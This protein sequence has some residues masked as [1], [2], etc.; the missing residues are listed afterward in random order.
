MKEVLNGFESFESATIVINI[1]GTPGSNEQLEQT[2]SKTDPPLKTD[3]GVDQAFIDEQRL[4]W[5]TPGNAETEFAMYDHDKDGYFS[6][7]DAEDM[8]D[9]T[10]AQPLF[11]PGLSIFP[12]GTED[13]IDY[14]FMLAAA[15]AMRQNL[16]Q[17]TAFW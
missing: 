14:Y 17:F 2:E 1:R 15:P 6:Y 8:L 12:A 16:S 9:S 13:E 7:F 3:A 10:E 11:Y 4:Y 5:Q